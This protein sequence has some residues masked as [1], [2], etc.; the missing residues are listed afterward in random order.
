[1]IWATGYRPDYSW[2]DAPVIDAESQV[3]HRRGLTDLPGLYFL[4]LYWQWTRGSALIGWVGD[5]AEYLAHQIE[6]YAQKP[7]SAF[8]RDEGTETA[9]ANRLT[10]RR[11]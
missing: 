6:T 3:R 4:G 1:V 7:A 8:A 10:A 5:D 2:L 11:G 9:D